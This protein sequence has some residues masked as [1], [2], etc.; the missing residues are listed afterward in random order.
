MNLGTVTNCK[1]TT[2]SVTGGHDDFNVVDKRVSRIGRDAAVD[3][4]RVLGAV[5]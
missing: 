2:F 3:E 1:S 5:P 4:F